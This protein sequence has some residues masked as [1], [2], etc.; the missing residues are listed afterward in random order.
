M[1][2]TIARK[3]IDHLKSKEFRDY[4]MRCVFCF[5]LNP[6]RCLS[7]HANGG[8]TLAGVLTA[9]YFFFPHCHTICL[10]CKAC[11]LILNHILVVVVVF[12][13]NLS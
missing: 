9:G 3:A 6:E 13:C 7:M 10:T 11:I 4:L 12:F 5:R 2:G 1:A 8:V